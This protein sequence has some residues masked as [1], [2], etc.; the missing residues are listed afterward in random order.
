M[1]APESWEEA[2]VRLEAHV[3]RAE[4]II[5]GLAAPD[6]ERD[7]EPWVEPTGLGPMPTEFLFRAKELL[8]RQQRLMATLPALLADNQAQRQVASKVS[9]ATATKAGP[10]YL[11]VTA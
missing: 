1:S 5:S 10:V 2:L 7:A 9:D 6:D 8:E 11:D 4:G 3:D